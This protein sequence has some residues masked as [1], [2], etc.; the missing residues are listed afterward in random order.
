[1]KDTLGSGDDGRLRQ[2][3]Q[4]KRFETPSAE[5]WEEFDR[6]F[7]NRRLAAMRDPGRRGIFSTLCAWLNFRRVVCSVGAL[8]LSLVLA[9]AAVRHGSSGESVRVAH[10]IVDGPVKFT[11]DSMHANGIYADAKLGV[12][13]MSYSSDGV[14]YVRDAILMP[15]RGGHLLSKI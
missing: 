11:N 12:R 14:C 13:S 10:G 5:A 9:V 6:S 8:S 1:M 4:L 15:Q 7:E 2:L 3:L